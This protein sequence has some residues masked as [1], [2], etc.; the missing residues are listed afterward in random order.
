M[1]TAVVCVLGLLLG[2][3]ALA[4][5]QATDAR[6]GPAARIANADDIRERLGLKAGYAGVTTAVESIKVA[7]LDYGFDGVE[8]GRPYLPPGFTLVEHYDPGFVQKF[9]LGD[10]AFRKGFDP[11]NRHGRVMAQ[12]VWAVSGSRPKG[13][14]FYLLN[15]NGPTMLR[16][17]V[18]YAIEQ[19]VDVI[20]FSGTFEGGGNGDGKGPIDRVVADAVAAGI[21][22]V[23]A[24]GNFGQR[25]YNGPVQILKDG[26]LRLRDGSDVAS[27]RF[28]NRVDENS[29]TVTLTWSDYRDQ[30]DAG[31]DKD[32]DLFVEDWA[33]RRVG[34]S[35]KV[36][37]SGDHAS[38]ANESRNPRER[39]VLDNLPAVPEVTNDPEYA[40]RIRVRW[41]R[42]NFTASDRIRVLVTAKLDAF[43]D[44]TGGPR[45]A[46]EFID[47]SKSCELFPPADHPLVITVGEETPTSSKGPTLDGRSKPEVVLDDATL[48]LTDGQVS[49][50][51]SNAAAIVAGAVVVLKAAE[52]RLK[53][54]DLLRLTRSDMSRASAAAPARP[55][56]RV[57]TAVTVRPGMTRIV[58]PPPPPGRLPWQVPSRA[59]LAAEVKEGAR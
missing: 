40:Y 31:T 39:V 17:A 6:P 34:S 55:A 27:L 29:V 45:A 42:G 24:S 38:A 51:S 12:A 35:E 47:A 30:E 22:W 2:A 28:R 44:P 18:R 43:A 23:N 53:A 37:V 13:P 36:Q 14:K 1:R 25:V 7:V 9:N 19:K 58:P 16:R 10:P 46:V 41:R 56:P 32:L 48:A 8:T 50:G 3:P 11:G 54:T 52:P 15:A 26:Y 21:I 59:R 49:A 33:G 5:T 4:Q 20:L 57:A